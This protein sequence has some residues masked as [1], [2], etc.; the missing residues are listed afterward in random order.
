MRAGPVDGERAPHSA[1]RRAAPPAASVEVVVRDL[2][3]LASGPASA[4]LSITFQGV[5][6]VRF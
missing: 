4:I 2:D 5:E 3:R 1:H 6:D